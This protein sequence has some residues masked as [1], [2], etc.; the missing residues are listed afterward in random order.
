MK[1]SWNVSSLYFR[2]LF[3]PEYVKVNRKAGAPSTD[4]P[5]LPL[6]LTPEIAVLT[7][8]YSEH[9]GPTY[10]AHPLS[11]RLTIFHGYALSVLHFPFGSA[12]HPVCLH[13]YTSF[14]AYFDYKG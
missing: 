1:P 13:Q 11:C 7:L 4:T 9:L 2:L 14:V 12:F 3:R 6:I 8:S 10:G 5:A